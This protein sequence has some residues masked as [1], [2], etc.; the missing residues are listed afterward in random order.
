MRLARIDRRVHAFWPAFGPAGGNLSPRVLVRWRASAADLGFG[1]DP[2][3]APPPDPSSAID[4]FIPKPCSVS[5]ERTIDYPDRWELPEQLRRRIQAWQQHS[6][7][8]YAYHLGAAPGTKAG[9]WPYWIQ[10]PQWPACPRG[11]AMDHLLTLASW[12]Y[13]AESRRTWLLPAR[14]GTTT[15][16]MPTSCSATAATCTSSPA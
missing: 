16:A 13:D 5:P 15:A 14:R 1:G 4:N 10:N 3:V 8:V 12:E 7:W 11:R 9:G 2:A 6:G